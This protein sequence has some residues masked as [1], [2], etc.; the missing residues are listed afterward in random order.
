MLKIP[1]PKYTIHIIFYFLLLAFSTAIFYALGMRHGI[2]AGIITNFVSL[3]LAKRIS[4]RFFLV[5]SVTLLLFTLFFLPNTLTYGA[6]SLG[7]A[8][9]VLETNPQEAYE[10]IISLPLKSYLYCLGL[11]LLFVFIIYIYNKII[12]KNSHQG[13]RDNKMSLI[14]VSLL[15]L[16]GT[17]YKPIKAF[18]QD[19]SFQRNYL[20]IYLSRSY[21]S[22]LRAF[23]TIQDLYWMYQND[24]EKLIAAKNEPDTWEVLSVNPKYKNHVI[25]IGESAT[26]GYHSL[27]GYP[28]KSTPF[29]DEVNGIFFN[30]YISPAG[31]TIQALK[32]MLVK[33][34]DNDFQYGNTAI[35]LANKAGFDTYWL[36]NQGHIG[37]YETT[38][39]ILSAKAG[40][41]Y[42]TSEYD[43]H[44]SRETDLAL[45][46][47]LDK[48]IGKPTDK[49]RV[50][51][52]HILGSHRQFCHRLSDDY[53]I[54]KIEGVIS[55]DMSCYLTTIKQ[56]DELLK[57]VYS[58]LRKDKESFSLMYFS[59]HGHSSSLRDSIMA[60]LRHSETHKSGFDVPMVVLSS[61]DKDRKFINAKKSGYNF[62]RQFSEWIGITV[63]GVDTDNYF[64]SEYQEDNI[65]A[66]FSNYD[67]LLDDPVMLP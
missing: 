55:G 33:Q 25:I 41:I 66:G 51:F 29:L 65:K 20:S 52:M 2:G 17:F 15:F 44:S 31:N 35:T 64:F 7:M 26:R 60:T 36:S 23:G 48:I 10:Y 27:Y 8:M 16:I 62:I 54:E 47:K 38:T 61:D 12:Q 50:I 18:Y 28:V 1:M 9:S 49:P 37:K 30:N 5:Y 58:L 53:G 13:K 14:I 21:Y 34:K 32:R 56:T 45:L 19:D 24:K 6:L 22:P 4:H 40:S 43:Y 39:S 63:Q 67:D 46:S 11:I 42:F 57:R 59:D 3:L